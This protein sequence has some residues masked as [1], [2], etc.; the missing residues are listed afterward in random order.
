MGAAPSG[1]LYGKR[2]FVVAMVALLGSFVL[3]AFDKVAG[4]HLV[5]LVPAIVGLYSTTEYL[6]GAAHAK[7]GGG[8]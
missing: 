2:K 4:E 1:L 8:P 3:A 7:H 5:I 6:E